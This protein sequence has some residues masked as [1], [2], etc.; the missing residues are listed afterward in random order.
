MKRWQ[1]ASDV[2]PRPARTNS[3]PKVEL[4]RYVE[5]PRTTGRM[6]YARKKNVLHHYVFDTPDAD[7]GRTIGY[8]DRIQMYLSWTDGVR[9]HEVLTVNQGDSVLLYSPAPESVPER[10]KSVNEFVRN[11]IGRILSIFGRFYTQEQQKRMGELR[12][13]SRAEVVATLG[14]RQQKLISIDN[15]VTAAEKQGL[16]Y[17]SSLVNYV[18]D[19]ASAQNRGVWLQTAEHN[20]GFYDRFGFQVV[21]QYKIGEL[22]PTWTEGLI[23]EYIL[24]WEP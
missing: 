10:Q 11:L 1:S 14:E 20:V 18:L 21:G 9:R 3:T 6:L 12:N 8:R 5:V 17:A 15:L 2:R 22:N 7:N 23:T 19:L 4:L 24:L 16:G 13:T